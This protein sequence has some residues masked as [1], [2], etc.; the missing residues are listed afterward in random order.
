[1]CAAPGFDEVAEIVE[2]VGQARLDRFAPAKARS[3]KTGHPALQFA[4]AFANGG[5]VPA[6]FAF[7]KALPART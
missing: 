4:H 5:A 1:M 6:E 2:Q 7:G 3:V